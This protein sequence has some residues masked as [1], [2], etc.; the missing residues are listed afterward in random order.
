M[1]RVICAIAIENSEF[2]TLGTEL[3]STYDMAKRKEI[4]NQMQVIMSEDCP[5][6]PLYYQDYA[7]A[8]NPSAYDDWVFIKGLG[9]LNKLSFLE[10]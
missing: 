2:D 8:Y 10:R 5:I 4:L 1:P 6:I 7:F 9:I 3:A